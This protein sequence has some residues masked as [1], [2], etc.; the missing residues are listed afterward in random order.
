MGRR[1]VMLVRNPFEH[2]TRVLRQAETLATAGYQVDVLAVARPGM[3]LEE[4]LGLVRVVRI[5]D[6]PL[7][8]RLLRAVIARRRRYRGGPDSASAAPGTVVPVEIRQPG[9]GPRRALLRMGLAIHL[10]L[11]LA[12]WWRGAYRLARRLPATLY[13]AHDLDALPVAVALRGRT[14]SRVVYDSHELFTESAMTGGRLAQWLWA[15]LERALIRKADRVTTVSEP[16]ARELASRYGIERPRV[17]LNAPPLGVFAAQRPVALRERLGLPAGRPIA[18]YLGSLAPNR[19]VEEILRGAALMDGPIVVLMGPVAT[20][21]YLEGLRRLAERY[22]VS[23]YVAF[24]PPLPADQVVR[25]AASADVGLALI[26]RTSLSYY[27]ALPNKL[28]E[29]MAAGLAVV[30]SDFPEIRRVIVDNGIGLLCDPESPADI[31]RA[32]N[33]VL[34]DRG[35]RAEMSANARRAAER[36]SWERERPKLLELFDELVDS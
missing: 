24:A 6:D 1:V 13:V 3:A 19:G 22:G 25:H 23:D 15:L 35:R 16:I 11:A 26:R 9:R 7:P 20:P 8:T 10:A 12:C 27:Y 18:L 31:A 33:E 29:Y 21:G 14:G 32:V 30:G 2:D 28:F 34:G 36:F 4:R 5:D 17:I